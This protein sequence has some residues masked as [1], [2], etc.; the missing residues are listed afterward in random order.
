MAPETAPGAA[1]LAAMTPTAIE[2]PAAGSGPLSSPSRSRLALTSTRQ[3]GRSKSAK[4]ASAPSTS[5]RWCSSG[6]QRPLSLVSVGG[7]RPVGHDRRWGVV[8]AHNRYGY[9]FGNPVNYTDPTGHDPDTSAA[10]R[11]T[12]NRNGYCTQGNTRSVCGPRSQYYGRISSPRRPL[13]SVTLGGLRDRVSSRLAAAFTPREQSSPPS[14]S[15]PGSLPSISK[16]PGPGYS[17]DEGLGPLAGLFSRTGIARILDYISAPSAVNQSDPE[18]I[19]RLAA[20][21]MLDWVGPYQV[22][23][24]G[25]SSGGATVFCV[26]SQR[27]ASADPGADAVTYGHFIFYDVDEDAAV[28]AADGSYS[29]DPDFLVHELVHVSQWEANG[30][31]FVERY[32]PN[33]GP[34]EAEAY[35]MGP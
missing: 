7:L 35:L 19:D 34:W 2:H 15:L 33:P 31:A 29:I 16:V 26:A 21:E 3:R 1:R 8:F 25:S 30:D 24:C 10:V 28:R 22:D 17:N 12:A 4:H 13:G 32:L 27:I 6:P 23:A 14:A 20:G 11:E 5:R 18:E 9:T